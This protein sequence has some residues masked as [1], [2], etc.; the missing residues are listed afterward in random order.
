MIQRLPLAFTALML[1]FNLAIPQAYAATTATRSSSF[2][3]DKETGLLTKEVIEPGN[4][5]LCLVTEYSYDAFGNK[6]QVTTRNC[7]GSAGEAAAPA[8]G[9]DGIISARTTSSS[10]DAKGQFAV[11]TTNALGHSESRAFDVRFGAIS[12][13]TGPN[14]LTTNWTYDG[15][16]RKTRE[17]RADGTTTS[18]LYIKP[19]DLVNADLLYSNYCVASLSTG[20]GRYQRTY[21]DHLNRKLST[22]HIDFTNTQWIDEGRVDYDSQGRVSKSFLP[23]VLGNAATAKYASVNYDLLGRPI[24]QIAANGS[25]STIAYAGLTTTVT[26]SLAQTKTTVKN[27]QGQTV[28]VIDAQNQP[29]TYHYDPFGNLTSTTDALGNVTALTYD[30][31]GRKVAMNDPDMGAWTY[32]YNALGE[33]IRQVDAKTQTV[34]MQY[35]KLGR[36]VH[37]AE[38]DLNS[39]WTYDTASKGIGKLTTA[40]SDN[41]YSRTHSYDAL[42]RLAST[43]TIIDNPAQPFV[44]RTSYDS[45]GR[46]LT[47]TYPTGFAV[48]NVYNAAGYLS[49]VVDAVSPGKAYWTANTVDTQGHLTLQTYGNGVTTQQMFDPATGRVVMQLTGAGAVQNM[50]YTYDR[51]GNV[52][53]RTDLIKNLWETFTYDALNRISDA[54]A[55]SGAVNSVSHYT[56]DAIGNITNKADVGA[57]TYNASGAGSIRPHA[58]TQISGKLVNGSTNPTFSY[59]ANGNMVS[60]AAR[61]VT[62]NSFNMPAGIINQTRTGL[63]TAAFLYNPEHERTK[64]QQSD[65]STVMTLSPRYDTGL[66]FEKKY[67]AA[68]GVATGAI[69]Y[70]HYLYAGGQMFGKYITT[71]ATDGVTQASTATEY[72]S[73]DNLGSMVAITDATGTVT[74]RMSYDI[75]GKRRY[76]NGFVDAGGLLNN[77]D[78]VH[79]FTGHEMLD[80]FELIHMNGRLYDPVMARFVSADFIIP[81]A[82]DLQS[83]NRYSYVFNN[84]LGYTDASGQCPWCIFA[85]VGAVVGRAAGVIDTKTARG[86]IGIAVGGWIAP[87]GFF[88]TVATGGLVGGISSGW[89]GVVGGALSAGLFYG[90]GS[91]SDTM[92]WGNGSFGRAMTHAVAGCAGASATGGSCENGALSA[93]F[94]EFAGPKFGNDWET[95]GQ[96]FKHAVLGGTASVLGGGKFANG[97]MTGAFGYLFNKCAHVGGCSFWDRVNERYSST[98]KTIDSTIDG[99]LPWPV[100]SPEGLATAA[101]GGLAANSYGGQTALQEGVKLASEYKNTSFSLFRTVSKPDIV[102]VGATTAVNAL[103]VTVAWHGG[104]YVGSIISEAVSGTK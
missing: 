1:G 69:E 99:A 5:Q 18:W 63:K 83:Y 15:L 33:L 59:D 2:T 81:D 79:G 67:I 100:N 66:H 8:A 24:S 74:Q 16:G 104:L 50:G 13:L 82:G 37:R 60:G 61:T 43:S 45:A 96:T 19:C 85:I 25:I 75:W 41:G 44:T 53:T 48:S 27:S 20:D 97:A 64:E 68:N 39:T 21:F 38:P 91:F 26:N 90:A 47:Q 49:Q 3:Y 56:Y 80:D 46:V 52:S 88:N 10:Y 86:I 93:G 76:P 4:S 72:Y 28:S 98:S 9:S 77:P 58:V 65:G 30:A 55:L 35:D 51:L 89:N 94:A 101:G 73:R 42:G 14:G 62:W 31:R 78:M 22:V 7:N 11:T 71:T 103:A 36:M 95:S 40:V 34:T 102:R 12:S 70:E 23:F 92:K 54:A 6:T 17:T 32:A 57:Y 29:V 87:V 84:P